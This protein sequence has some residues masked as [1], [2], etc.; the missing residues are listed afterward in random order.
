VSPV[1]AANLGL[2]FLLELCA[3]AAVAYWGSQVSSSTVVNVIVAIAAPLALA[4]IWGVWL[5][6]NSRRRL[7]RPA[8]TVLELAVLAAAVVALVAVGATLLALALTVV[9]VA[10]GL[11]LHHWV[12]DDEPVR[13]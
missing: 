2:R 6:P 9:A 1:K 5:A 12:L 8:R 10:N 7:A 13:S 11:L 3:L 4:T